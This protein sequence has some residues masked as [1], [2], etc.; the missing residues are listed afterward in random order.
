MST[1][2]RR[3]CE[4]ARAAAAMTRELDAGPKDAVLARL[5]EAIE[6]ERAALKA[7]NRLD[8]VA[9]RDAG[10]SA[11]L[12]DRLTLTDSRIGAMANAVRAVVALPDPVGQV[13]N[14]TTRP[15]GLLIEHVREPLGVVAVVYEARPN[16]TVDVAALCLKSAN[17][18]VL[19]G[20]SIASVASRA[21]AV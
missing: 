15:N 5:A 10:V 19:R 8:L 9:A 20:S 7:A 16:V 14:G 13:T 12:V 18:A 3:V 1:R 4:Q 2:V 11:T 6:S 17:A 21:R